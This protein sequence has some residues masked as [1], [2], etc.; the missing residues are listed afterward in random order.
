MKNY[1]DSHPVNLG[2]SNAKVEFYTGKIITQNLE[3]L[4]EEF[5]KCYITR[6]FKDINYP[7]ASEYFKKISSIIGETKME[8]FNEI[9]DEAFISSPIGLSAVEHFISYAI[10][11][12]LYREP[13]NSKM[14]YQIMINEKW[15]SF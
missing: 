6:V 2:E 5:K 4:Y 7:I 9:L 14:L 12:F 13:E 15:N 11:T 8:Q 1:I 10:G 3:L